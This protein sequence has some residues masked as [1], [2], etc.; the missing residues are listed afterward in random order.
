MKRI[1]LLLIICTGFY[2]ISLGQNQV[3]DSLLSLEK[4]YLDKD[5]I[6]VELLNQ[7]ANHYYTV[8][9]KKLK[10]YSEKARLLSNEIGYSK[11]KI[12]ALQKIALYYRI[13]GKLDSAIN[14][15]KEALEL[16]N[17]TNYYLGIAKCNLTLGN[18]YR[19]YN[20]Y[21]KSNKYYNEAEI[22]FNTINHIGGLAAVK[23]NIA[24]NLKRESHY[25]EALN[26]YQDAFSL[27]KQVNDVRNQALV[28]SNMAVMYSDLG[29]YQK[30]IDNYLLTIELSKSI[31]DKFK[32]ARSLNGISLVLIKMEDYKEA[33]EYIQKAF[34]VAE[35]SN[36]NKS[37][38]TAY[39]NLAMVNLKQNQVQKAIENLNKAI[40]ICLEINYNYILH[41]AYNNIA[42][43]YVQQGEYT[44]A[45]S[46][47]QKA[48][49]IQK[50]G[51]YNAALSN[52]YNRIGNFYLDLNN[53]KE[54]EVHFKKGLEIANKD[55]NLTNIRDAA[56][57]LSKTYENVNKFK[58]SLKYY[59]LY[60]DMADS[61]FNVNQNKKIT[62]QLLSFE[63]EKELARIALE[64]KE[65]DRIKEIEKEKIQVARNYSFIAFLFSIL[66]VIAIL[67][68]LRRKR[69]ANILL[70]ELHDFKRTMT[71]A[72]VHDLKN[73][74]NTIINQAT[75]TS[76]QVAGKQMLN[77]VMNML[78]VYKYEDGAMH[79]EL[80]EKSLY[81]LIR[82]SVNEIAFL[83]KQKDI[84]ISYNAS[85]QIEVKV[86]DKIIERV[87]VNLL[88][89]AIKYS[90]EKSS[91][92][93]DCDWKE[94]GNKKEL[95]IKIKDNGS[96]IPKELHQKI[97]ERFA[98]ADPRKSGNTPSTGIG[99][100]FCK[101]AIEAHEGEIGIK[102]E[103]GKGSLF[104]FTL[105]NVRTIEAQN[106][107]Y[108]ESISDFKNIS[109]LPS[110]TKQ[111]IKE[112][113]KEL[114]NLEVYFITKIKEPL[115]EIKN[116]K[117]DSLKRWEQEMDISIE[118]CNNEKYHE[119][120]DELRF[121]L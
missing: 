43:I 37:I 85:K 25:A 52:T 53:D 9:L 8:D 35:E 98:Q 36:F 31:D 44:L 73:P 38:A 46:S 76:L 60:S 79:L 68:A 51:M 95:V 20:E 117:I 105:P 64:Q 97:F 6:K 100:T 90:P 57:G 81:E 118:Q 67:I 14:Y 54:A 106:G 2:F 49:E 109:A 3:L 40:E 7:I 104:W 88:S 72:F 94:D 86:D 80:R 13:N 89:N 30:A 27:Y 26:Y 93:V 41:E 84:R 62:R 78:D 5:S 82:N 55:R 21:Q 33:E 61:I 103:E 17:S 47:Y 102:S 83:A 1:I 70:T 39:K 116:L 121:T 66:L 12:D 91:V 114:D 18:I 87:L 24:I 92:T 63:H 77:M 11:G 74:L 99:L 59:K 69:K 50:K 115:I 71:G 111:A 15:T 34:K 42:D 96:G 19:H 28:I 48:L 4:N 119:L 45:L 113:V 22:Y 110:K 107:I 101:L 112:A 29:D 16:S 75:S 108:N 32:E 10:E 56:K 65:K 58:S 23:C 120:L